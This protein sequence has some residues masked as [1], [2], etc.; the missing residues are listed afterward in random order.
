MD[1]TVAS[2]GP[3]RAG[4]ATQ[5][6]PEIG[7]EAEHAAIL[8]ALRE[9][10]K[11]LDC[12][13]EITRLSQRHDL[14]L[15]DILSGVCDIVARA[16]Q[17]PEV[18]CVRLT[19]GGRAFAANAVRR[20]VAKQSGR[21]RVHGEVVGRLEVGYQ[22]P[23]PPSDEGPFLREERH[24]LN[25]VAGHLG[26]IIE[27]REN[28]ERLRQLS[29]ELIKAQETER[30]RIA[31]ELHD[32]VG[33]ALSATR[34]T[35][36]RLLPLLAAGDPDEARPARETVLECS[37]RLGAAIMSLRDLAYTLLPPALG[38][39]GLAETAFRLCEEQ[40]ARYGLPIHF[41]ADGMEA[42]RLP[43]ETS[44]NLYRV[45]QEGL[46]NACRHGRCSAITV[47]LLASHP[48]CLL[49]IADDGQGFD[50]EVRLPQALSEKRMGLWSMRERVRLLGGRLTL[51]SRPGQGVRITVEVPVE[52][53]G[54]C[55]AP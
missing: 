42:L 34:L 29:R 49:R 54:P 19:V 38:Q 50:P 44:I 48:H 14:A 23:C 7:P 28:E 22:R 40:S 37:T 27:A 41:F 43:F 6:A 11:E 55:Q 25:A 36:D 31:R 52:G 20:P 53:Q 2:R 10:I 51:R 30:Q 24:L 35:L 32:D 1:K 26:R 5:G 33:Q 15:D 47:R 45:L 12:L 46:A 21:I 3:G 13:Y 9:R 8:G 16:W 4:A 39:L 18:A 17:Y